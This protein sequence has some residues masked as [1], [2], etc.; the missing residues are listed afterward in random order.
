MPFLPRS[1]RERRP[2][3]VTN[4]LR[5]T[6]VNKGV[7]TL[8]LTGDLTSG[9]VDPLKHPKLILDCIKTVHINTHHSLFNRRLHCL[10]ENQTSVDG[11]VHV[12][13]RAVGAFNDKITMLKFLESHTSKNTGAAIRLRQN[14]P[15]M[16]KCSNR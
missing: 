6:L 7:V 10:K 2:V 8:T 15:A 9:E 4:I 12:N 3:G 13:V 14:R 16:R 11:V 1:G 5:D